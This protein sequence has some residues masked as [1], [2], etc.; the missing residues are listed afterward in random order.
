MLK[1]VTRITLKRPK[2]ARTMVQ[3]WKQSDE[4]ALDSHDYAHVCSPR[5]LN[6]IT[7]CRQQWHSDKAE[8]LAHFKTP[9]LG[10]IFWSI[11]QASLGRI[12]KI[13]QECCYLI[14]T[15]YQL[16]QVICNLHVHVGGRKRNYQ[17]YWQLFNSL[18]AMSDKTSHH[19]ALCRYPSTVMER[20]M[21]HTDRKKS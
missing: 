6:I 5:H 21:N 12:I 18:L 13:G 8:K 14:P 20:L 17:V 3:P 1:L 16:L 10:L 4:H 19:I 11:C 2:L 9:Y 15:F 7:S